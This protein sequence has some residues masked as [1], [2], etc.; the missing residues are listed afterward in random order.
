MFNRI[1][2]DELFL[3]YDIFFAAG[4]LLFLIFN[5]EIVTNYLVFTGESLEIKITITIYNLI[6]N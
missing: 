4:V 2:I 3:V 6:I 1:S 5:L